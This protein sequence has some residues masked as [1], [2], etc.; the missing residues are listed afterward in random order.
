M[1][2]PSVGTRRAS[3]R[4]ILLVFSLLCAEA[5]WASHLDAQCTLSGAPISFEPSPPG[6]ARPSGLA[7]GKQF[8]LQLF[9]AGGSPHMLMMEAFGYS[10]LDVSNPTNPTAI[11]YDDMRFTGE[12]P[13][14]GDGQSYVA[15]MG[16]SADGGRVAF[17]LNSNASPAFGTIVGSGSSQGFDNMKGDFTPRGASGGTAILNVANRYLAFAL[18]PYG[19]SV[20][21]G[22]L[23]VADV[24]NLP[25]SLT[26]TNMTSETVASSTGGF[27]LSVAGTNVLYIANGS[28]QI[29]N[30][31]TPGPAGNIQSGFQYNS[32]GSSDLGPGAGTPTSF[33]AAIDPSD[34][35]K[36]WVLV[37]TS[38][39]LEYA[40]VSV[41][42][43]AKTSAGARFSIPTGGGS[44]VGGGVS[45]LVASGNNVFALMWAK[46]N[47]P[48]VLY[49]LFS[50]SV[51][52][53]GSW[54]RASSTSIRRRIPCSR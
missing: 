54:C 10:V 38:G 51:A 12:M 50:N 43:G 19:G 3:T 22:T 21:P 13:A 40:L 20:N 49:R 14:V 36:L 23:S 26:A 47:A 15:S 17:S 30:A 29:I 39:P 11:V 1:T 42:G 6:A 18:L 24:T 53:W 25:S 9:Q 52:A 2:L 33:S 28:I 8:D 27:N 44:W 7:S 41:R 37:E 31:S 45:A 4:L 34:S 48:N 32:I 46:Q 5:F 35:S 16:V